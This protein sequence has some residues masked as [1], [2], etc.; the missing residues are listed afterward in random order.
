M[1]G[2]TQVPTCAGAAAQQSIGAAAVAPVT[3]LA[4]VLSDHWHPATAAAAAAAAGRS[5]P[6]P[7]PPPSS[8]DETSLREAVRW[9]TR[10]QPRLLHALA[11]CGSGERN[12]A[13]AA[14]APAARLDSLAAAVSRE[15]LAAIRQ[16]AERGEL[17]DSVRS[18]RHLWHCTAL[19]DSEYAGAFGALVQTLLPPAQTD[20]SLRGAAHQQ[21]TASGCTA[22]VAA[23]DAA[24][25]EATRARTAPLGM[26][27]D[28]GAALAAVR[29][30][31]CV[32]ML[33][34]S[35]RRM[36]AAH[37]ST[38]PPGGTNGSAGVWPLVV[39]ARAVDQR[40]SLTTG[41]HSA[42]VW[43]PSRHWGGWKVNNVVA[44]NQITTFT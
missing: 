5:P 31:G 14:I 41:A 1:A 9:I 32:V 40:L 39:C 6:P 8:A 33:C 10:H 42:S 25:T 28:W 43:I 13:A 17:R 37:K 16:H 3:E 36:E 11:C 35:R 7:P 34:V 38:L 30:C 18:L 24:E 20:K 22:L 19:L 29:A 2:V 4:C 26:G 23:Y 44:Q 12:E 21:L 15:R 27:G